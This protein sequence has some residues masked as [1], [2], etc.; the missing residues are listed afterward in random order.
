[1]AYSGGVHVVFLSLETAP[2]DRVRKAELATAAK[3]VTDQ[4]GGELLLV[5]ANASFSQLHLVY[6]SFEGVRPVLRRMVVERNLPRR[7][8]VQQV[9][10]IYWNQSGYSGSVQGWPSTRPSTLSAVTKDFFR[11]V[12][13]SLFED[14][15]E[16]VTWIAGFAD[17]A[18]RENKRRFV[19]TLFNRL[20]FV[21]FLSRKGWLTFKGDKD[22]L[23]ALWRDYQ[24]TEGEHK[25]F[26]VDRLRLLFF[27]GLNNPRSHDT[28]SEPEAD[29]LIGHV[30]FLNGGLFEKTGLDEQVMLSSSETVTVVPD[31]AIKPILNDLFD[32]FNFTVMESTPFDVEIAVDPEML[33]K[34]FEE[35]VTGRHDS[36]AYYTPRPVV[37]FMCREALK[38]YLEGQDTDVAPEAIARFVD[39]RV[40]SGISS[41]ASARKVAA[42]LDEVTVVDPACGSGAYLLGM[43][44]ELVELQT[45]LFN[46][47]VD[48][49]GLYELK[50]HIIERNLYGVDIDDFAVNIAM[51]RLW[52][53][54]AIEFEGDK[55]PPLPNLDFKVLCGDSLLGPDPSAGVMVQGT[56]GYDAD[57]VRELGEL[58]AAYMRASDG[59]AKTQ[60]RRQIEAAE[61]AVLDALGDADVPEGI[62]NWRVEFA[63]VFAQRQ[64]FDIA[65]ANPPYVNMVTMD[66]TASDYRETLRAHFTTARG[67][68]DV[69][70]PFVERGLQI[71][72][73]TGLYAYITPNKLL[74][75]E[76]AKTLR[77]Y[78]LSNANLLSV[79]DL[80]QVSIFEAAVYP[81]VTVVS[82]N[83][84][85][86]ENTTVDIYRTKGATKDEQEVVFRY[87]APIAVA[88]RLGNL[89]SPLLASDAQDLLPIME[90]CDRLGDVA[91]VSASATVDEAYKWKEAILDNGVQLHSRNPDR[92]RPFIVSGN[93]RRFA[94]TWSKRPTQYIKRK[95]NSPVIDTSHSTIKEQRVSQIRADK[96]IISGMSKRITCVYDRQG[97]AAGTSTVLVIGH[98]PTDSAF[99][100]G[101]LNSNFMHRVYMMMFGSLSLA[102]GYLRFGSPQIRE[103]PIPKVSA[104]TQHLFVDLVDRIL[105]T[106]DSDPSADT[107]VL[108]AEVDRLV[109]SLYGMTEG[110]VATVEG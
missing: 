60:L 58:K 43:M 17:E 28:T 94:H 99:I 20:M 33:G 4:L 23:N 26:Y 15:Q 96:L 66:R 88:R 108:E 21:Y 1:M 5:V 86:Q 107:S 57:R 87:S 73:R 64:G 95:Y 27:E 3:V 84:R 85:S 78:V 59:I 12:Q 8:A 83:S 106:K 80:S 2:S 31:E 14:A 32:H 44:Q 81:V 77:D 36:G 24:A 53:S 105:T 89:W 91:I 48:Q 109:Y 79:T 110:E 90:S 61:T 7:T 102:G 51:L 69:F 103:L 10:N 74:A 45:A 6:P 92:Y 11:K 97:I 50:L 70:V 71:L 65:V 63:E 42:A 46:V 98:T 101:L 37:S 30:P 34:V 19:Q 104:A 55:P 93:I 76:Y 39:Q 75:A 40:T 22:Y 54:L 38:G 67:G 35:L 29:R 18:G 62:V 52:L 25:N 68:F 72:S 9:S 47:G 56:L 16:S 41:V 13:A 82:K 49:K 100:C